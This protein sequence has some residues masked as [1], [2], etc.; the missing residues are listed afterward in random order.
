MPVPDVRY[1]LTEQDLGTIATNIGLRQPSPGDV[2]AVIA[3]RS[4][5][6]D[7]H[8]CVG[9]LFKTILA[10]QP[11]AA[12][13][14]IFALESARVMLVA[15]GARAGRVDLQQ[16]VALIDAVASYQIEDASEIGKR[17]AALDG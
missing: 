7:L 11:Y 8:T 13:N 1:Y 16:A 6:A 2:L 3:E 17:I 10:T 5:H 4:R 14:D 12:D 9:L 15:N